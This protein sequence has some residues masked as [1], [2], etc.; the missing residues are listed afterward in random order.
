MKTKWFFTLL[1]LAV[2]ASAAEFKAGVG[3][4][5]I[6][7]PLPV[8]L[9][10]YAAR[11]NAANEVL[12]DLWAKA[13]ALQDA[14]GRRAVIVTTDLIGL[15]HELSAEVATQVQKRYGLRRAQLLL[16]SS[17]THSG[18]AVWPN[19]QVMF[20]MNAED[21]QRSVQYA[22][23]LASNLVSVVG[24]ALDDLAPAHISIGHGEAPFAINRRQASDKGVRIGLNPTGP[25]DHDVPVLKVTSP[26]G[27]LRAIL[28][29]Y[30]CHNTTL[31]ANL[32]KVNGD[33]AGFAQADLEKSHPGA[34]AMFMILCGAD[35]N[36]SPRG[37][38]ELAEQ[39][40]RTLADAVDRVLAG[41]MHP[42]RPAIRTAF[43]QVKLDFAPRDRKDFETEAQGK[44]VFKQRRA[45]LMLRAFDEGKPVRSLGYPVQALRLADDLTFVALSG[46]VVVDYD[47][48]LKREYP[49]AN[50]IVAGYCNEVM[51]YIPSL[52]VLREGGY[53][54]V[55]S[56]IYYGQPG[57][58][59]ETVEDRI[60]N[61]VQQALRE[62]GVRAR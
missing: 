7:P 29:A 33:Y 14:R 31:G 27:T 24:A 9:S 15:P 47:L 48:R 26:D 44:D 49:Q 60:V 39:H 32:Y 36:P 37:T 11:T 8:W 25:V 41:Q 43:R 56:M 16:N 45:K 19:L 61:A 3:R 13:L 28:F 5:L 22:Q 38:I 30:A 6:T 34:T 17:H 40:G 20:N 57:P 59:A 51:C 2:S 54:P 52:R 4:I 50:L 62:V 23:T 35:Q 55:D 18:P 42:L 21:A 46:E 1:L 53:E 10:G 12:Q 58:F